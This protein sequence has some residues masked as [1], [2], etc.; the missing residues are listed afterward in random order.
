MPNLP[1]AEEPVQP[2]PDLV[3]GNPNDEVPTGRPTVTASCPNPECVERQ[4]I[5]MYD[6]TALPLYCGRCGT[7][8]VDH[9]DGHGA[10]AIERH[11]KASKLE[12]VDMD[13]LAE[14]VAAK[15]AERNK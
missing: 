1:D 11:A 13:A 15:L 8:L 3:F 9:P 7:L 14:L 2:H 10:A 5:Q 4:M 12:P 6:D